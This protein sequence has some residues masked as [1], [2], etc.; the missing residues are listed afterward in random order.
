MLLQFL[1]ETINVKEQTKFL[2]FKILI[3]AICCGLGYWSHFMVK[4]P[5][6]AYLLAVALASYAILM[7]LH[8]FIENKLEREAYFITKSHSFKPLES[9]Q[10]LYL[11]SDVDQDKA[12]YIGK[13]TAVSASGK[14]VQAEVSYPL[15]SMFDTHGFLHLKTV[16]VNIV[17]KMLEKLQAQAKTS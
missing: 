10:T 16:H 4:F 12:M 8:Y 11:H 9:Y 2:D 15:T 13:V 6:E 7:A 14:E 3:F 17:D 5:D 1:E